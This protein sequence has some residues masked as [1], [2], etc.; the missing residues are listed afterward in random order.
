MFLLYINTAERDFLKFALIN[1]KSEVFLFEK[2]VSN[3]QSENTLFLLDKFL[4]K[5]RIKLAKLEKIIVN[6]GPGSFTSVRIGVVLANTLSNSLKIP[7]I[8][9]DNF[10]PEKKS[11]Y[12]KL[13]NIE[14][15]EE[16][17]KPFYYKEANITQAKS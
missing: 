9:I 1:K 11:D 14:S 3:K 13:L 12:I 8:G 4:K 5:N 6:R 15:K 2:N 16:F 17:V 10:N 7:V